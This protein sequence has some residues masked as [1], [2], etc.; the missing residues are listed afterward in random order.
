MGSMQLCIRIYVLNYYGLASVSDKARE[1]PATHLAETSKL[2]T[3]ATVSS[4]K[5]SNNS[6]PLSSK[7]KAEM[8]SYGRWYMHAAGVLQMA[9]T[10]KKKPTVHFTFFTCMHAEDGRKAKH[11]R[12][13]S[14]KCF[15]WELSAAAAAAPY[16]S[17]LFVLLVRIQL[18]CAYWLQLQIRTYT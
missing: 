13:H 1:L 15:P 16:F 5:S 12:Q 4:S 14:E 8:R 7:R 2:I 11:F 6:N 9:S 17:S 3:T 18:F 10:L